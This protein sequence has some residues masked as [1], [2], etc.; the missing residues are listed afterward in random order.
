MRTIKRQW[1]SNAPRGDIQVICDYCGIQWRRSQLRRDRSGLLACPDD[2]R[3]RDSVTLDEGNAMGAMETTGPKTVRDAGN[4]DLGGGH[5]KD[6][7]MSIVGIQQGTSSTTGQPP[8]R[9]AVFPRDPG[10][11]LMT[12][13]WTMRGIRVNRPT[14]DG[15]GGV[16]FWRNEA[17]VTQA[18]PVSLDERSRMRGEQ[19]AGVLPV[20]DAGTP[21]WPTTV[22]GLTRQD[23]LGTGHMRSHPVAGEGGV[24]LTPEFDGSKI[25]IDGN[26]VLTSV[27]GNHLLQPLA[28]ETEGLTLVGGNP[29]FWLVARFTS[30][31]TESDG[32]S[33]VYF[34]DA[35]DAG[36]GDSTDWFAL[37]KNSSDSNLTLT[38]DYFGSGKK[39]VQAP[40][41]SLDTQLRLFSGRMEVDQ[42]VLKI[43]DQE[44][45]QPFSST[46]GLSGGIDGNIDL[47]G[48][49]PASIDLEVYELVFTTDRPTDAQVTRLETYF[50][51]KFP[52]LATE[53]NSGL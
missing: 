28:F 44:F 23:V 25:V 15:N 5:D 1:P 53:L 14:E 31:L 50:K 43:S 6:N 4:I 51:L 34:I 10:F 24:D 3:G 11:P 30:A 21:I 38:G 27:T 40:I 35:A 9:E 18:A 36:A 12:G 52:S 39:S 42:L 37:V 19:V 29:C 32:V 17:R 48:T 46:I 7:P 26:S 33:M 49:G 45:V 8:A 41:S 13:W 47:V 16:G 22:D 20:H 2:V